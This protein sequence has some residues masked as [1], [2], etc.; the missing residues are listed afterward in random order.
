MS[1]CVADID[2]AVRLALT[3]PA[4]CH[5]ALEGGRDKVTAL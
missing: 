2:W 4:G 1:Y 5:S 3:G